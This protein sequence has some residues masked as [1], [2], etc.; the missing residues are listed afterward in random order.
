MGTQITDILFSVNRT[1]C[2]GM[3][4]KAPHCGRRDLQGPQGGQVTASRRNK[5]PKQGDFDSLFLYTSEEEQGR[6]LG[7][8]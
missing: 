5:Q 4:F 2:Q 1:G 3:G 7:V 6:T 8:P